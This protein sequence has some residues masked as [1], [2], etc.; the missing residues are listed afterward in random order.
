[1]VSDSGK[2]V[3]IDPATG[4]RASLPVSG[5]LAIDTGLAHI[6]MDHVS[7]RL[8]VLNNAWHLAVLD[9]TTL[10]ATSLG[11][12]DGLDHLHPS[13]HQLGWDAR[14]EAL[15]VWSQFGLYALDSVTGQRGQRVLVSR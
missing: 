7:A 14:H 3:A 10:T 12:L 2:I 5:D 15:L 8:L 11:P 9:L 4:I 13:S 6:A 1:M